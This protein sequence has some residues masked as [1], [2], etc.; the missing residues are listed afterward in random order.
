MPSY[1]PTAEDINFMN[2]VNEIMRTQTD[3]AA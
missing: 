1:Q 2:M 3:K